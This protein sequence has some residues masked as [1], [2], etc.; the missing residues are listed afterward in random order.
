M[1]VCIVR[2]FMYYVC[3][4]CLY[5]YMYIYMFLQAA[6]TCLPSLPENNTHVFIA[7]L[8]SVEAELKKYVRLNCICDVCM[9]VCMYVCPVYCVC[10][11]NGCCIS[12]LYVCR[13]RPLW[14]VTQTYTEGGER[15]DLA[16]VKTALHD[17][18]LLSMCDKVVISVR[19]T[20]GYVVMALK[21][22]LCPIA[23]NNLH[24]AGTDT[25]STVCMYCIY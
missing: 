11:D 23:G 20:F 12:K 1:Y 16:Q 9:Y 10:K 7:S 14:G 22:S 18:V 6:L 25:V 13:K 4:V 17:M 24:D 21:G 19:S 8:G 2:E 3:T 15:H 5:V